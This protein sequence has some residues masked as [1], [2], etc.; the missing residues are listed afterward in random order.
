M[1]GESS[2]RG[3]ARDEVMETFPV[4]AVLGDEFREG[5]FEPEARED[6]RGT[7]A[8]N[9]VSLSRKRKERKAAHRVQ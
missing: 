7:V 3:E 8:W 1:T 5:V 6:G 4:A 2:T 9:D